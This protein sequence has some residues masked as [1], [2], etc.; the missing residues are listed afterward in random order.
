MF[1]FLMPCQD[2][3]YLYSKWGSVTMYIHCPY[4]WIRSARCRN[5]ISHQPSFVCNAL[6]NGSVFLSLDK[7]CIQLYLSFP[8]SHCCG[9]D[10]STQNVIIALS[11]SS[12]MWD[13]HWSTIVCSNRGLQ[14]PFVDYHGSFPPRS[15]F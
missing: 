3:T 2:L 10:S 14:F 8:L 5:S 6:L 13:Q 11:T 4:R 15:G 12:D 9:K 7:H 1:W